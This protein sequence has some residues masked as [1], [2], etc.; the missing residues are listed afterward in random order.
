MM[1]MKA[2][3]A[4]WKCCH[5][6]LSCSASST[7][8]ANTDDH[9]CCQTIFLLRTQACHGN[10]EA[11]SH[12][13][14]S[15]HPAQPVQA[16]CECSQTW[17]MASFRDSCRLC[18]VGVRASIS[19]LLTLSVQLGADYRKAVGQQ[20]AGTGQVLCLHVPLGQHQAGHLPNTGIFW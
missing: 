17:L 3:P 1:L 6:G 10:F 7:H 14:G 4:A 12:A 11:A 5:A 18:S 15:K 16:A 2:P 13:T 19:D 9:C 20:A 8:M